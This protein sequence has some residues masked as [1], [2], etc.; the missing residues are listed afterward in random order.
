M[1]MKNFMMATLMASVA[2]IAMTSNLAA[3]DYSDGVVKIGVLTDLS[4][5]LT[6]STGKGS[7]LAAQMA[8]EDFGAIDGTKVEVI[9]ADHQNKADIGAAKARQWYDVD[10]VDVIVDIPNSAVALAVQQITKDKDKIALFSSPASSDLTGKA[11][12]PNGIHWTYDTYALA[13]VTAEAVAASGAKKWSF[14]TSDY[15]FGHAL[16]RDTASVVTANGG[17]VVGSV[18]MPANT[19]DYSS[20]LL[21]AQSSGADVVALATAGTDTQN[22][23]KQA[24]EFGLTQGGQK[25]AA[26]L[27]ADT[28]VNALGL[29]TTKGVMLTAPFY[30]AMNDDT[31]AFAKR[32]F[33]KHKAMPTFYQAGVY[34]AV[35]HYLK[36]VKAGQTDKS[37]T[38]LKTMRDTPIN[39]FMTKNGK[40]RE[41]G[42]VIRDMYLFQVKTPAESKEPWDYYNLVSTVSGDKAARPLAESECT[43]VKK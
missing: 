13:H 21:Q 9:S 12:T 11:C 30:W 8:T 33:A 15:A 26:L 27:L 32:F 19:P 6:D 29:E 37:E 2:T 5:Q 39:D 43:L 7:I 20:F 18:K 35:L 14:L 17:Q 31:K 25:M 40:I 4:G 3:A 23:L 42:R 34:S 38:V 24:G 41:D 10:K 28:E 16:E 1:T 22:A 36:A